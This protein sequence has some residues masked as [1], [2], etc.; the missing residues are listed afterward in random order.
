[1]SG[2][3]LERDGVRVPVEIALAASF[4]QALTGRRGSAP[5]PISGWGLLDTG[6]SRT[7]V[8]RDVV[9]RL[10][11]PVVGWIEV[12]S[13]TSSSSL[14]SLH[15]IQVRIEGV[16]LELEI[17]EAIVAPLEGTGL[18]ALIGRDVLRRCT[19]FYDGIPGRTTLAH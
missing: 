5:A 2:A 12:T 13:A 15:P 7:C 18:I 17:P 8:D 14:Q 6:A 19:L 1:M 10:G 16:A 11:L 4:A 9:R 3:A